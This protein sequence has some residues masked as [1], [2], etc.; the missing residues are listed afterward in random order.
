MDVLAID[1]S[2]PAITA[3]LAQLALGHQ[4]DPAGPRDRVLLLS[5]QEHIGAFAHAE[6]L[7][8]LVKQVLSDAGRALAQLDAVVVGLGPGPFTGLRVGIATAQALGL[9]L[10]IP[11]YG[12]CSH[13]AMALACEYPGDLLVVTDARRRE[14]YVSAFTG[15]AQVAGPAVVTPAALPGWIAE[16][17]VGHSDSVAQTGAGAHL[18]GFGEPIQPVA[19][20]G[21]GLVRAAA[22]ALAAGV[23]PGPLEPLYLRR[24][25]ATEPGP[26]KR[27]LS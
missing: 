9:G 7:M 25:D 24:P 18:S 14:V 4:I 11:V 1:T 26:A 5:Q 3:A 8:P 2:T 21:V 20:L 22:Q 15:H 13:D 12:V 10:D 19:K 17:A 27:V 23:Q 6:M 16:N